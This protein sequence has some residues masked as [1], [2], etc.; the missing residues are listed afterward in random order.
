MPLKSWSHLRGQMWHF[1]VWI[2]IK[3]LLF[4]IIFII[5]KN[6]LFF[7]S[8]VVP[9]SRI[10][11]AVRHCTCNP[12]SQNTTA[13]IT[14][15][16]MDG[17]I[18]LGRRNHRASFAFSLYFSRLLSA[19]STQYKSFRGK[20]KMVNSKWTYRGKS[21]TFSSFFDVVS[22]CLIQVQH[23]IGKKIGNL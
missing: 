17:V 2:N 13:H 16:A 14:T 5:L 12:L 9:I 23:R 8:A 7:V 15:V 6:Q 11:S 1:K 18:C 4:Y 21:R 10:W 20:I 22:C 3:F 19:T